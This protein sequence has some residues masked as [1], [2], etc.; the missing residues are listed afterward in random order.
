M[1]PLHQYVLTKL[2]PGFEPGPSFLQKDF[3]KIAEKN[4]NGQNWCR[5]PGLNQWHT[6]FQSAALPTELHRQIKQDAFFTVLIKSQ[7]YKMFAERI[8]KLALEVNA[9]VD[10]PNY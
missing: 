10:I 9:D 2:Y 8:L 7:M 1:L 6:D 4:L 5:R 3:N